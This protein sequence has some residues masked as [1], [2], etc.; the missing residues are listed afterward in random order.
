MPERG[1]RALGRTLG[2]IVHAFASTQRRRALANVERVLPELDSDARRD[3]VRSCFLY[4]GDLLGEAVGWLGVAGTVPPLPLTPEAKTTLREA[5]AEGRGVLFASAHLGP[6]HRVA[7]CIAAS[8][9]PFFA[10]TRDSYDPRF[11]RVHERLH[12]NAGIR[13]IRRSHAGGTAAT[14]AVLRSLRRGEV[15]GIPMDLRA[16]VAWCDA[17]FLGSP[18]PS[19]VGPARIALRTRAPVVVGSA[20]PGCIGAGERLVVTATRIASGD[21]ADS[22]E[23]ARE[24]TARINAELS[25][26]ILALPHAWVWMHPR[27]D[28]QGEL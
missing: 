10:V 13:T 11:S 3:L 27:W 1:R 15:V 24:L 6:W 19:S 22:H 5:R 26:R 4:L 14:L 18:A 17:P 21:I 12:R 16:R 23:G 8:G 20:A 7:A 25:R 28:P 9:V 2:R